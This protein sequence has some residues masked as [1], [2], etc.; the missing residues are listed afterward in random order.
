[1][2]RLD[3]LRVK[4]QSS[5]SIERKLTDKFIPE[6]VI[7]VPISPSAA[8]NLRYAAW[9][10]KTRTQAK[11]LAGKEGFSVGYM[12]LRS[13]TGSEGEDSFGRGFYPDYDKQGLIIDVRH[14][15]GGNIDSW[16]LDV[17]QRRA[18][19]FF[20]GRATNIT[21]GGMGWDERNWP[22]L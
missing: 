3:V 6:P 16:L 4:S 13:M 22:L 17:L 10:W 12:H 5:F 11:A 14:N 19:S 18:W 8:A 9:E 1:M 20:Q 7:V 21:T 15:T 2:I